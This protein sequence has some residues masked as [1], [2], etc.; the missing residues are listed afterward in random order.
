MYKG[1]LSWKNGNQINISV[2]TEEKAG[3][4]ILN[5]FHKGKERN[6]KIYLT[7]ITSN[8]GFGKVWFFICPQT[9]RKCRN[10]YL[11]NGYFLHR[12]AGGG[13]YYFSQTQTKKDR[14]YYTKVF[15]DVFRGK[16][17][18][19]LYK[20]YLKRYYKNKPTKTY[21]KLL[22][23]IERANEVDVENFFCDRLKKYFF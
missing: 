17:E 3:E 4:M 6:Y 21:Q 14:V 20:P 7:T 2:K 16:L 1:V 9:K 23:R 22:K 15:N 8:L 11:N 10:L 19:D 5:Y 18:E 12:E 13:F